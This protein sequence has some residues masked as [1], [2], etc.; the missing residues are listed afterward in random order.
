LEAELVAKKYLHLQHKQY[1][2][3]HELKKI[4]EHFGS[5]Y[6]AISETVMQAAKYFSEI[7]GCVK[8]P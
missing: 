5:G 1:G 4:G 8:S 7:N 6:T 2:D 3:I